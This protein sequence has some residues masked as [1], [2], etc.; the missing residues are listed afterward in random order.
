MA[1]TKKLTHRVSTKRKT[2]QKA[3]ENIVQVQ[4]PVL[5]SEEEVKDVVWNFQQFNQYLNRGNSFFPSV[6]NPF[7]VNQRMQDV[8]MNPL[9]ATQDKLDSAL[10][11]PKNSENE[12]QGFSEYFE[13]IS[14][15][16]KRLLSYLGS[17]LSWDLTMTCV[18][19]DPE[20]Y[21]SA[22]YK[23]DLKIVETLLDRFDYQKE[24]NIVVRELLRNEAFF[25]AP[26]FD[27]DNI[28]LQELPASNN[29]TKI[30][31]KWAY[32]LL[33]SFNMQWFIQ[34]GVDINMY[35]P[36]F[37]ESFANLFGGESGTR[38]YIP[39]LSAL[40]RGRSSWVYWQDIP[41]DVG[42]VWKMSPEMVTRMPYFTGLF[43]DLILQPL[44]RN[45]QKNINMAEASKILTGEVPFLK[46]AGAK[47]KDALSMSPE[48]L[49]KFLQLVSSALNSAIKV[50]AAPLANMSAVSFD[51]D[52]EL[53]PQ[54]LRNMLAS[55]GVNTN[56]VFT[57]DVRPNVMESQLS[58][59]TDEQLM[60]S[61]Y[62]QFNSFMNYHLNKGKKFKWK[63]EF[64]GTHFFTNRAERLE[65]QTTL[66]QN[67][68][69][70]PQKISAAVGMR[71]QDFRKQMEQGKAEK[72]VDKLTPI[73]QAAQLSAGA[74][75]PL[76]PSNKIGD[77]GAETRA[78][79]G[80]VGRGGK[81]GAGQSGKLG[82]V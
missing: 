64:E 32:G 80:N 81:L 6:L 17:M 37:I 28:V 21:T 61:L 77:A 9:S 18:N 38:E 25:C 8:A 63:F 23:K 58:L 34:A 41:V 31:G 45:L 33:F 74:G 13:I 57:S 73:L 56:L 72:F 14:Q 82:K 36:F 75:R 15:P 55:S 10:N 20:D 39:D 71:Y 76:S 79:G 22:A 4:E 65:R 52:N 11:N 54:Y 48:T 1:R 49:A 30:T 62:P 43:N 35:P 5:L 50:T 40:D 7:L 27:T 47:V 16:Y 69:I 24:F 46:D 67:G 19:A 60:T 68:I 70:L 78:T 12:L 26:R 59:N 3:K 44:M 53:Y 51:G 66:M 29:Y 42:W 2:I